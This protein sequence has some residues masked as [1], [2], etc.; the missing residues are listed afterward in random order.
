MTTKSTTKLSGNTEMSE[1]ELLRARLAELEGEQET[2]EIKQDEYIPVMSLIPYHLNLSTK[3]GGQGNVKRFTKFGEIKSILY[4]DLLDII[5]VHPNF[6]EA[7]YFY[8]LHSGFIRQQG[9]NEIYSKILTK[10][11]IEQILTTNT[12]ECITL[13]NSANPKQQ[14]IIIQLLIDKVRNEPDSINLNTV[15]KISRLSKVDIVGKAEESKQLEEERLEE[16]EKA[17][18]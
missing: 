16:A 8:I 7:G 3:E 9:L 4:K 12:E 15:D 1:I 2:K 11:K 17:G 13:Y 18:A 6:L 14:E 10:D 5:E